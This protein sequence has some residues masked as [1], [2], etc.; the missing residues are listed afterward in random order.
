MRYWPL[1]LLIFACQKSLSFK[2]ALQNQAQEDQLM[3]LAV[4]L[5]EDGSVKFAEAVGWQDA[6]Q[7]KEF[8]LD[9]KVRIAS[10]SKLITTIAVM[11]LK[12]MDSVDLDED[13]STY[14]GWTLRN[15]YHAELPI[16]LR[17]LLSHQSSIRDGSGYG[18]F[19]SNMHTGRLD[20]RELFTVDSAYF[21]EDMFAPEAPGISF[22]YS[23]SAWGLVASVIERK[24][25]QTFDQ[26]CRE[27]IFKPMGLTS[28]Y[29][30][31]H[32]ADDVLSPLYRFKDGQWT[33]QVDDYST[34]PKPELMYPEYELGKNGLIYAPQGGVRASAHD[35]ST[36]AQMLMSQGSYG[37][38]QI[39]RPSSVNEMTTAHWVY[40]ENN[41]DTWNGFFKSYGLG[42]HLLS[43]SDSG[44]S[45]LSSPMQG[46][47][48]IAYGLLS[49]MYFDPVAK[50]AVIFITNGCKNDFKYAQESAFY[51]VEENVFK[52]C[53]LYLKDS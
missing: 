43:N 18:E 47:A 52:I 2:E 41:G 36:F 39:L 37:D 26:Y 8:S 32:L 34:N 16:T 1:L 38:Q 3:G 9:A 44:D 29:N 42:V 53:R 33:A 48:G 13:V 10:I 15:P 11:Q 50:T 20:I 21:T 6:P 49:D 31:Q 46:H 4:I 40:H 24:S 14:L 22:S 19:L 30:V 23:N 27:H 12:E 35:L 25:G 28:S 51:Q 45:I 5:I 7:Q 17:L